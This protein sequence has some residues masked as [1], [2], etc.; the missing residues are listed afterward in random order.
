[1]T[2]LVVFVLMMMCHPEV[3]KKA[4]DEIDALVGPERLPGF[5]DLEG[6]T[7][8]NYIKQEVFR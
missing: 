6:L 7:Y 2:T 8:L 4:Q 3:Q 1:M 5:G